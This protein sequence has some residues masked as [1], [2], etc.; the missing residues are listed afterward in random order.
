[1]AY[2]EA[3]IYFMIDTDKAGFLYQLG[4]YVLHT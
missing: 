2:E 1:M 3:K 4:W